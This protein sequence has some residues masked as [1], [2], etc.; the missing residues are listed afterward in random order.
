LDGKDS[1]NAGWRN[2][3]FRGFADYLQ[4]EE[5]R[6][7]LAALIRLSREKRIAIM[8]ADAVPWCCHRSVVGDALSVRGVPVLR[9]CPR[10]AGGCI[11]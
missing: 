11:S 8:C 2:E 5:F 7:A 9:S 1:P 3:A 10:A 6:D 4:T